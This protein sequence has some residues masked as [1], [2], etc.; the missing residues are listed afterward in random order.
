MANTYRITL[1]SGADMGTEYSLDKGELF[2]GRDQNN[3]IVINDPEVS[4]RHARLVL[5]GDVYK[6]EDLGSTNGTF[7]RGQRLVAPV[8]LRPGEIITLGEKIV[9]RYEASLGDTSATVVAQRGGGQSTQIAPAPVP[10]PVMTPPV[11]PAA[12]PTPPAAAPVPP[13]Q[14]PATPAYPPISSTP[15]YPP[16]APPMSPAAPK[17]KSKALI[18]ILIILA[19]FVLFCV[20]PLIII[21]VTNSYCAL[22][23]GVLNMAFPGACP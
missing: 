12:V 18:I 7:I 14:I 20:I 1:Q 10:T 2:I 5:E 11:P 3:D 21:D 4:R 19:I 23:P 6:Y 9:L 13:V 15:S 8:V 16:V 22:F 17:K